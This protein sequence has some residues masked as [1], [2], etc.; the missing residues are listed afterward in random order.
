MSRCGARSKG[1]D[2]S[3]MDRL[4]LEFCGMLHQAMDS[5][6]PAALHGFP[7]SRPR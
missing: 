6:R 2:E 7:P 4:L 5:V 1:E 3:A